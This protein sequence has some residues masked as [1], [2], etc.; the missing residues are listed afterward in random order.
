MDQFGLWRL[1]NVDCELGLYLLLIQW[2]STNVY[3]CTHPPATVT[4]PHIVRS[5]GSK[6][7]HIQ[8]H[9]RTYTDCVT[10]YI[11]YSYW[12][13]TIYILS[14]GCGRAYGRVSP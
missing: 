8:S 11:P 12:G 5:L 14:G 3:R 1:Y 2:L 10:L 13:G 9:N 6:E 4:N 7:T